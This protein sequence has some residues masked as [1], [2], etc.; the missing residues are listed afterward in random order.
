MVTKLVPLVVA[1]LAQRNSQSEYSSFPGLVEDQLATTAWERGQASHFGDVG[2]RCA[3]HRR[4]KVKRKYVKRK[5]EDGWLL[6]TFYVSYF[7][8]PNHCIASNELH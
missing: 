6:V 3:R 5:G 4:K 1:L 8:Y 7:C 2:I